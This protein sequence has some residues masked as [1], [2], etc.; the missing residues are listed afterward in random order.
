MEKTPISNPAF[1]ARHPGAGDDPEALRVEPGVPIA[2]DPAW[3]DTEREPANREIY[4][5]M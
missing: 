1:L 2:Q 3:L 5:G 4:A